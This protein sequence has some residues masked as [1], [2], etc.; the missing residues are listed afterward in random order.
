MRRHATWK[1]SV[2]EG[3]TESLETAGPAGVKASRSERSA[4]GVG[5]TAAEVSSRTGGLGRNHLDTATL[6]ERFCVTGD[7]SA[8]LPGEIDAGRLER[9][10]GKDS[11]S[12]NNRLI[13][14]E[15][16]GKHEYEA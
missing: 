4:S 14:N 8:R 11:V 2:D 16:D 7:G 13:G 1:T 12:G 5:D 6:S 15:N 10:G 3:T 9:S